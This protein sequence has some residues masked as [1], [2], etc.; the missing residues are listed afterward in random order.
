MVGFQLDVS[1]LPKSQI[2][3]FVDGDIIVDTGEDR[4]RDSSENLFGS[5]KKE[6]RVQT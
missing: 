5:S 4:R 3:T 2:P 1:Q 6:A